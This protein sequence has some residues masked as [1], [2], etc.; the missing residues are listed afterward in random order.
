MC[1]MNIK[2]EISVIQLLLLFTDVLQIAQR[3]NYSF[4]YIL[5]IFLYT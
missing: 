3:K 1:D 2:G 5:L 4:Y